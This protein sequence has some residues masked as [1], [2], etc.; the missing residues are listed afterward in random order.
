MSHTHTHTHTPHT[1][2]SLFAQLV[3]SSREQILRKTKLLI[4]QQHYQELAQT[5]PIAAISYL[6][7][8][9]SSLVNHDNPEE[10]EQVS[11]SSESSYCLQHAECELI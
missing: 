2:P 6:Q 9:L 7:T 5:D 3:R 11:L 10:R 8:D 1:L 4:R